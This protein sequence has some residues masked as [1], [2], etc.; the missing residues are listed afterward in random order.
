M[1]KHIL[2][3]VDG[4][5]CSLRALD[6]AAK[7][8]QEQHAELNVCTIVDITRAASSMT[9]ASPD[10][11]QQ[12]IDA[13]NADASK[14]NDAAVQRA[15][16]AGGSVQGVVEDAFPPDGILAAAKKCDADLIVVGSHGRT[17]IR[18]ALIGSVAES[19]ARIVQMPVLIVR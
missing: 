10:L 16:A 11:V 18:R 15:R 6:F 19:V 3:A 14:E 1:F 8:A 4:S 12:W 2:V 9:F 13:L 17:G 5:E 7:L